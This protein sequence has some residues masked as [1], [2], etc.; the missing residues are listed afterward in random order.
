M[1]PPEVA[2]MSPKRFLSLAVVLVL[3][4]PAIA[5]LPAATAQDSVPTAPS[6]P[7]QNVPGV[8]VR[9]YAVYSDVTGDA[10]D[11][12]PD[13]LQGTTTLE[14]V[15]NQDLAT[16]NRG[17]CSYTS[18]AGS[19]AGGGVNVLPSSVTFTIANDLKPV[20]PVNI[21]G[22]TSITYRHG[23]TVGSGGSVDVTLRSGGTTI[24]KGTLT[25]TATTIFLPLAGERAITGRTI[26][27]AGQPFTLE[28]VATAG[29]FSVDDTS[30]YLEIS[31]EDAI[32]AAM[33]TTDEA[34]VV[35]DTFAPIPSGTTPAP[36][37]RIVGH[38]ALQSAYGIEDARAEAPRFSIL[39]NGQAREIGAGGATFLTGELNSTASVAPSGLAVWSFPVGAAAYA[40]FPAGAY[41][42][43]AEKT[44]R[45]ATIAR[46]ADHPFQITSQSV[47][48][49]PFRDPSLSSLVETQAHNVAPGFS[50]TYLLSVNNTGA[51]NDTFL[52]S[53]S[54]PNA[55]V[56]WS[57]TI[58][59]PDVQGRSVA[60]PTGQSRIVAITVT[61]PFNAAAADRVIYLA[62]VTSAL[63]PGARSADLTLVT[64]VSSAVSR[65]IAIVVPR[66]ERAVEPGSTLDLP[67]Y[68]WNRGTRPANA[69]LEATETN[70]AWTAELLQGNT[71]VGRTV[72]SAIPAGGIAEATL[73]VGAPLNQASTSLEVRLN[74]TGLDATGVAVERL[75]TFTLRQTVGVSL[76]VLDS[77]NGKQHYA[78][79]SG[80]DAA[81]SANPLGGA[82]CGQQGP[83]AA[84]CTDDG[85]DGLW[86]RLWVTNTG[87]AADTF[88]MSVDTLR[89]PTCGPGAFPSK[90]A[91][92]GGDFD[93]FFRTQSGNPS[94]MRTLEL[95]AGKTGEVYL[96]VP[97]NR[98]QSACAAPGNEFSLVVQARS[99]TTNA[100]GRVPVKAFSEN[101]DA[102]G[103]GAVLVEPVAREQGY[104][105]KTPFVDATNAARRSLTGAVDAGGNTTYVVRVTNAAS[106]RSYG[107]GNADP[108]VHLTIEGVDRE[109]GWN[110]SMRPRLDAN[111]VV[112]NPWLATYNVSNNNS[113]KSERREGWYD[114]EIEIRVE[115]P[116]IA[117]GNALARDQDQIQLRAFINGSESSSLEIKTVI[118]ALSDVQTRAE[119]ATISVHPGQPGAFLVYV[120]NNGSSEARVTMRAGMNAENTPNAAAWRVEPNSQSFSLPAYKYATVALLVTP[121]AGAPQGTRGEVNLTVE[122]ARNP[123][124][125]TI[126]RNDTTR[127]FAEVVPRGTLELTAATPQATIAPGGFAN[128][129]MTLRN[130]GGLQLPYTMVAAPIPNWTATLSP[131]NGTLA[132]GESRPVVLVLKAPSDVTDASRFATVVRVEEERNG[133]NFD[134]VA[135]TANILGGKPAPSVSA[136][137]LAKRVDRGGSSTFEVAVRNL[138]SAAGVIPIEARTSDPLWTT[139]IRNARGDVVK[140]VQ[141]NPNELALVNVTVS[142]P[143]LVP[144]RTVN[145]VEFNAFSPD[146]TQSSRVALQAEIH[147]YG[148][149]LA[150]EPAT[151][152]ALPGIPTEVTLKV[153][154]T[155]ND[156]DTLNLSADLKEFREWAAQI[157]PPEIRLEPGAT[158]EVRVTLRPPTSPLPPARTYTFPFWAGTRGG[159]E[160][161]I[162]KEDTASL[163]VTIPPYRSFD[164]DDDEFLEVA[165]D[166]DKRSANG[167]E[168]FR[169]VVTDGLQSQVVS[170]APMADG[171]MR[172]FLDVPADKPYDGVAD[173][174]FDPEALSVYEIVSTPDLNQDG[175]PDYLLDTDRDGKIDMAFDT[176]TEKYTSAVEINAFGDERVQ[177]LVDL[178]GDGKPD[179]FYDP[180][181]NV[182]TKTTAASGDRVGLDTDN[183]NRVDKYYDVSTKDVSDATVA[184]VGGFARTYWYFFVAFVVLVVVSIVLFV[185]RRAP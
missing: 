99:A 129:T 40:G 104:E 42:L 72:L 54:A 120:T 133:N 181:A 69:S 140:S 81:P 41:T 156:N 150:V 153:R 62:N 9:F 84:D 130:T 162:T 138:G 91:T 31:A 137:Q 37:R 174:W 117:S 71:G 164:V 8:P 152:D 119:Q 112:P 106:F 7:L 115:A 161:N 6:V 121:P 68:V 22:N 118:S 100:I 20:R 144:E 123:A 52:V 15:P 25:P 132:P 79:L 166:L 127:L 102:R 146:L 180:E 147:D 182:V 176:V 53:V 108:T 114:R 89:E 49:E 51:V 131:A 12:G 30:S 128:F 145:T 18:G 17:T 107:A 101:S 14:L 74:S 26:L 125:P 154:N 93:F 185:R 136:P 83:L 148:V 95:P 50:T 87:K 29:T 116:S 85:I 141:L 103:I 36:D 171:K 24:A 110:V 64:S 16:A 32:R 142:A 86:Y 167:F 55:P 159:Q 177:Y 28:L 179:R 73:R 60:V 33:W 80:S 58:G 168:A 63:D 157:S 96:F 46:V 90:D 111:S 158:G 82:G 109:A 143:L 39:L 43:H 165:V 34:S 155:G 88:T 170:A 113:F 35:K 77:I 45:G 65:E 38:Y 59:G 13:C 175:T 97:T 92:L 44:H 105:S 151:R 122:Y 183:D 149:D 78:E 61:A 10:F 134:S 169:E 3:L 124:L 98:F 2:P 76:T 19:P 21:S 5:M 160:V 67:V 70:V 94:V 126:T 172:F 66:T 4:A 1:S 163:V 23:G 56:G 11:S 184:N 27:A 75:L 139:A 47:R 135:L 173:V 178:T 48:F 57:A